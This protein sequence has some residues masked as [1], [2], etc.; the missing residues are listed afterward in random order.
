L[1]RKGYPSV[2]Q[3]RSSI[4]LKQAA[5]SSALAMA[6]DS[7]RPDPATLIHS[8]QGTQIASWAFTDRA[9]AAGLVPFLAISSR[10]LR[11]LHDRCVL[12]PH[13]GRALGPSTLAHLRRACQRDLR[14][15]RDLAQPQRRHG[16]GTRPAGHSCQTPS[17]PCRARPICFSTFYFSTFH[18]FT[19]ASCA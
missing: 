18:R 11:Q 16:R 19:A 3:E 10:L 7:R 15:P 6:I 12:V 14:L 1:G 4:S 2:P 8:G 13:A 9:R 17:A 5:A